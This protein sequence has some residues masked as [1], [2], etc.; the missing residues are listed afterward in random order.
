MAAFVLSCRISISYDFST[1]SVL[2]KVA[3]CFD[4]ALQYTYTHIYTFPTSLPLSCT[5]HSF[6]KICSCSAE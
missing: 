1:I 6:L 3:C 2:T 5:M 4:V